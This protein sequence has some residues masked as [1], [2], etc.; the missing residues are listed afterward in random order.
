M[1]LDGAMSVAAGGLAN[2]EH[3]LGVVSRNITDAATLKQLNP[4]LLRGSTPPG[5]YQLR[6]PPGQAL[7][8]LRQL[9]R[10]PLK[11]RVDFKPYVMQKRDTL[12]SVAETDSLG[13]AVVW[14]CVAVFRP[15][16][17]W[18]ARFPVDRKSVV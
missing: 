6:V 13:A 14:D 4:E 10:L 17:R 7:D 2:I 9:A 1:S 12:A 5:T 3:R 15:G 11:E 8:C 16:V 18:G